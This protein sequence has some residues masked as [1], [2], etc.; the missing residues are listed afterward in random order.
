[1]SHSPSRVATAFDGRSSLV[2]SP[3]WLVN[4]L[5]SRHERGMALKE[6]CATHGAPDQQCVHRGETHGVGG[7]LCVALEE[8][9]A[10]LSRLLGAAP[11]TSA[12]TRDA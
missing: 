10:R 12:A 6:A 9:S 2:P 5:A 7:A 4:V 3:G 1:M 8:A 11:P